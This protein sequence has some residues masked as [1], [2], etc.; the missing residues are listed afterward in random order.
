MRAM[1]ANAYKFDQDVSKWDVSNVTD[2]S[3]MFYSANSFSNHDLSQW[4]VSNVTVYDDFFNGTGAN[5]I[6]PQWHIPN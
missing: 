4:D 1:F 5:N 3:Y 2:M 6:P